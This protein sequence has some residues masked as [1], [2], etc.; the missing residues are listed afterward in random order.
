MSRADA[1]MDRVEGS[2]VEAVD[3]GSAAEARV[4]DRAAAWMW[5]GATAVDFQ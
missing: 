4:V 3:E 5:S 2:A 1:A